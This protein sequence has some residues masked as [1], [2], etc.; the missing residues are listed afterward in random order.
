MKKA[1]LFAGAML[2]ASPAMAQLVNGHDNINKP[3]P[4][5]PIGTKAGGSPSSMQAPGEAAAVAGA[6]KNSGA[7]NAGAATGSA[8]GGANASAAT[9]SAAP[10]AIATTHTTRHARKHRR[11]RVKKS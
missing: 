4:E 7:A 8:Y 11:H 10:S 9:S 5:A 1:I 3:M 2:L 6:M